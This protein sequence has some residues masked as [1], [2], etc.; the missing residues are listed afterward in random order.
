M[1]LLKTCAFRSPAP[2][3]PQVMARGLGRTIGKVD[4]HGNVN[5]TFNIVA[6]IGATVFDMMY[7]MNDDNGDRNERICV[8]VLCVCL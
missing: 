1:A 2:Q 4:R 3:K 8:C 6:F 5:Y 7:A